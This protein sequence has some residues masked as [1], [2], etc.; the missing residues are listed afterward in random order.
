MTDLCFCLKSLSETKVNI[1][2]LIALTKEV[3]EKPSLDFVLWFTL[4][5]NILVKHSQ[6]RK[7]KIQNI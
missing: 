7:E 5:R 1:F 2:R 6:L 4:M 3:S